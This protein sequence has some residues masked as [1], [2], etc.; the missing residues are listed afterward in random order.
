[1]VKVVSGIVINRKVTINGNGHTIDAKGNARIFNIQAS[2]VII[3]NLTI[4]N[5]HYNDDGGAIYFSNSGTIEN[6]NFTN[7]S[8]KYGGAVYFKGTGTVTNSTFTCNNVSYMGGALYFSNS[9]S[10]HTITNC[11]FTNNNA[12]TGHN[13]GG[14]VYMYYGNISKCNFVNNNAIDDNSFGGAVY[15][16]SGNVENG[17]NFVNNKAVGSNYGGGAI[18]LISGSIINSIFANNSAKLGGAIYVD[19][20]SS[21]PSTIENCNFTNNNAS[22]GLGAA[23]Y[24][25]NSTIRLTVSNS[26]FVNNNLYAIYNLAT[27]ALANNTIDSIIYNN[28]KIVTEMNATFQ[29]NK[30][31]TVYA[32]DIC[33]LNATLTDDNGNR[34]Y[35]PNFIFTIDGEDVD[36]ISYDNQTGLYMAGYSL[37][38]TGSKLITTSYNI[39]ASYIHTGI[40]NIKRNTTLIIT[41]GQNNYF[42]YSDNVTVYISLN[43]KD[44]PEIGLNATVYLIVNNT[45]IPVETT[46]GY[47][48][49]NISGLDADEYNLTAV[50]E[51]NIDYNSV[52]NSTVFYV[53]NKDRILSIEVENIKY[54]EN[55]VVNITVTDADGKKSNGTVVLIVNGTEY[56]V[57]V[58]GNILYKIKNLAINTEGYLVNAT[59]LA[60]ELYAEVINDT[61]IIKVNKADSNVTI[62]PINN[63]TYG[64]TVVIYYNIENKTNIITIN[65]TDETGNN[66]EYELTNN[67]ISATGLPAGKYSITIHNNGDGIYKESEKTAVFYVLAKEVDSGNIT[68]EVTGDAPDV[69]IT[70]TGPDANYTIEIYDENGTV[71]N[72]IIVEVVNG[73][74]SASISGLTIGNK[75]ANVS[76]ESNYKLSSPI[77]TVEFKYKYAPQ[78]YSATFTATYPEVEIVI[79]GEDGEYIVTVKN[80]TATITVSNGTGTGT[81][82][83]LTSGT[84]NISVEITETNSTNYKIKWYSVE[85]TKVNPTFTSSVSENNT[86]GKN[87]VI[88]VYAPSDATGNV[89]LS[90]DGKIISAGKA[91]NNGAVIFTVDGLNAGNHTYTVIY[92]GD[93]NYNNASDSNS[94]NVSKE[95][96]TDKVNIAFNVPTNT[97]TIIFTIDLPADATGYL[98]VNINGNNYSAEVVNGTAN[99]IITVSPDTYTVNVTYTGDEKYTSIS[100]SVN[101]KVNSVIILKGS[102]TICLF[103]A[104]GYYKV[105]LTIDGKPAPGK[106]LTFTFAGKKYTATTDSR[107]YATLKLNTKVKPAKYTIKAEYGSGS[108]FNTVT[109]KNIIKAKNKNVKKSKK[110]TKIVIK[111]I[112]V[113]GKYIKKAKLKI[114]FNGKTYKVKTSKKGQAV[115]KVKKS[116]IK[117]LKVGKKYKYRVTYGKD[118]VTKK[119]KIKK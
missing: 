88:T 63:V 33:T 77:P 9:N 2:D 112:K 75:T 10:K 62:N 54:G 49:Y 114:K 90:V 100:K 52:N 78:D 74:G 21:S 101:V 22:S 53:L 99:V 44:N 95:N 92:P 83:G 40:L 116:M 1:M 32:G 119:L 16:H 15:M 35:D 11:N 27:L 36:G 107:G 113:N 85:V 13:W 30:T 14:A 58:T 43:N 67:T 41:T 3:K 65:I 81:I 50:F 82:T 111:L 66:Y 104:K 59:L 8:A 7:N 84:Y 39:N 68:L 108:T 96:S 17:C 34:I 29:N 72:T 55:A 91:L 56:I 64:N 47:A 117:K 102:D 89:S 57:N 12:T 26:K 71:E 73:T 6:C 93:Y 37:K 46:N 79:T 86:V 19:S 61:E 80:L 38:D 25:M 115:W 4:K 70:F 28:G 97:N 76:I 118:T 5:A 109:V 31:Y 105:L 110:V 69:S 24:V 45:K 23:I 48:S 51:G 94:F 103:S 87:I 60:E 18:F 106:K 42:A 20:S 98:L